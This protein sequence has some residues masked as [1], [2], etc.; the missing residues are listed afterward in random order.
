MPQ[1]LA[2]REEV[3]GALISE[4]SSPEM[5]PSIDLFTSQNETGGEDGKHPHPP[6]CRFKGPSLPRG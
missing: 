5:S 6:V 4:N 3:K 2:D 1:K